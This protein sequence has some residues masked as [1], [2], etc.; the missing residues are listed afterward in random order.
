MRNKQTKRETIDALNLMICRADKALLAFGQT[1]M[2]G[3]EI[4]QFSQNLKMA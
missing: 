2:R 3:A 4:Q 1:I